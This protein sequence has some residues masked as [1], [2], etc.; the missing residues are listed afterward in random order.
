[1]AEITVT[2][3]KVCWEFSEISGIG[4]GLAAHIHKGNPGVAGPV[5]V[6]LG[7]A[8]KTKGCTTSPAA[9]AVLANPAAYYVNVHTAK[10]QGGAIRGQFEPESGR[11][12]STSGSSSSSNP[13]YSSGGGY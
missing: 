10:F 1:E 11:S 6:P 12:S 9:K 8:F 2:G 13:G 4:K 7:S 5:V 3:N